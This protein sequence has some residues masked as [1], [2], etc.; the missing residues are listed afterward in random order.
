MTDII[1]TLKEHIR[2]A[3]SNQ[4]AGAAERAC[5]KALL[6]EVRQARSF[7][8]LGREIT[9]WQ[10]RTFPHATPDSILAHFVKEAVELTED[11]TAEEAADCVI[12]ILGFCHKMGYDLQAEIEKKFAI[13]QSRV[14]GSP[15]EN[16]VVEH[17]R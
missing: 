9:A 13:N 8:D 3:E 6:D 16:G 7:R 17:V 12:L 5:I 2:F 1:L 14:W 15:D 11:K 4:I 10:D